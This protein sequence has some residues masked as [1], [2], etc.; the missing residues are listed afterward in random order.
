[1]SHPLCIGFKQKQIDNI[2]APIHLAVH[3][4]CEW[5]PQREHVLRGLDLPN[6]VEVSS[7]ARMNQQVMNMRDF[8]SSLLCTAE[9]MFHI[10][11]GWVIF[12]LT[13]TGKKSVLL[14]Q[15]Y[16]YPVAVAVSGMEGFLGHIQ[17]LTQMQCESLC[18]VTLHQK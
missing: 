14:G 5:G 11:S 8:V 7:R 9:L 16:D 3:G 6:G 13:L 1:M 4:H 2:G 15:G 17:N 18:S 10:I 12:V